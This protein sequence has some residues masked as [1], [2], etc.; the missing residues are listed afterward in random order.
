MKIL[1][2]FQNGMRAV[3]INN[4]FSL[5]GLKFRQYF[6]HAQYLNGVTLVGSAHIMI[7][8]NR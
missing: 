3:T 6:L 1:L 8:K 5:C 2:D 4:P 7:A